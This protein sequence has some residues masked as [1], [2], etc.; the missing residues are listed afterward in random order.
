MT[1][2]M[3]SLSFLI[4]S[5]GMVNDVVVEHN[6][7]LSGKKEFL[8]R[9]LS[10]FVFI[11]IIVMIFILPY[12]AFCLLGLGTYLIMTYEI[13]SHGAGGHKFLRLAALLIVLMG[14]ISFVHCRSFFG[15]LGCSFLICISSLTDIGGYIM[16]VSIGGPKLCPRISPK[17]TWAGLIGG[18]L[19]ANIGVFLL[20]EL[21]VSAKVLEFGQLIGNIWI[22]QV[23]II[24]SVVGDLLES[25]FKRRLKVKDIG[26][27]LPGHGGLLDRL[28]SLISTSIVFWIISLLFVK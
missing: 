14:M 22:T 5:D 19:F 10:S 23:L 25:S 3:L 4:E 6:L 24:S 18:I 28:D 21:V 17:K 20:K 2:I 16:G 8:V 26:H 7:K 13:L 9:T 12:W 11:P 1:W 15:P 27:M